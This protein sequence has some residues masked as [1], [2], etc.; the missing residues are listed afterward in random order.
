MA[1]H[2]EYIEGPEALKNFEE[3]MKALFK[4]PKVEMVALKKKNAKRPKS[5]IRDYWFLKFI[6]QPNAEK[7]IT[8]VAAGPLNQ[9]GCGDAYNG[10]L[11]LLNSCSLPTSYQESFLWAH[12]HHISMDNSSRLRSRCRE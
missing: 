10:S 7:I 12:I 2:V 5:A 6:D 9:C 1:K 4:A 11:D 8:M 3:G